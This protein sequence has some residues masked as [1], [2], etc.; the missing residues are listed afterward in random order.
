[1]TIAERIAAL[2]TAV[3]SA[4]EFSGKLTQGTP[5]PVSAE[6]SKLSGETTKTSTL[7]SLYA[8]DRMDY[9]KED[10]LRKQWRKMNTV[11]LIDILDK[12]ADTSNKTLN[13]R[14]LESRLQEGVITPS[15]EDA[16]FQMLEF[17]FNGLG[18]NAGPAYA[19]VGAEK[20]SRNI[21][22]A[23]SRYAAMEARIKENYTGILQKAELDKLEK[24]YQRTVTRSAEKY[25]EIVGG[26]LEKNGVTGEKEK[27]SQAYKKSVEARAS[28]Y[29]EFLKENREFTGV[30]GTEN[31][32]L[33]EDDE[34]I[35]ARLREQNL[36]IQEKA[37]EKPGYTRR[38]LEILGQYTSEITIMEAKSNT[39]DMNEERMGLELA[40]LAM[41]TDTIAKEGGVSET[42]RE[43]L[44]N[45]L[46]GFT[47]SFI[48]RF[49]ER[50]SMNRD[51]AA[52]AY[53][54]RG[55]APLNE[56][57][58]WNVYN[59][60]LD[61]YRQTNDLM[62]ALVTGATYAKDNYNR[63]ESENSVLGIYRYMNGASYWNNFFK[64][65]TGGGYDRAV[66]TYSRHLTEFMDFKK[67]LNNGE[68]LQMNLAGSANF[69]S[70]EN[71]GE[72]IS[73][74]A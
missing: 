67:R 16:D 61:E 49:D 54:S 74:K 29:R 35:A 3:N 19:D 37:S 23:A 28:Q 73:E 62:K 65:N 50:L 4:A 47:H 20:V 31:Q 10:A 52:T 68:G 71:S 34:Y 30:E 12:T 57:S 44:E 36:A 56:A 18:F 64:A 21:D 53:D 14:D 25:A 40:M 41:K 11:N 70:A 39:Y 7:S 33:L 48:E 15:L 26:I 5:P 13:I 24:I 46:N 22:Y 17:E 45:T 51:E 42:L 9:T 55:N 63:K 59:K 1:M 69:Y 72:L 6:K 2:P 66:S 27:L 58:V 43:T 38:D 60:T 32:W 8:F